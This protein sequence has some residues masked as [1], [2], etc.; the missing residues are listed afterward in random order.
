M[1]ARGINHRR[2]AVAVLGQALLTAARR[3]NQALDPCVCR[4]SWTSSDGGNCGS[5]QYGCPAQACDDDNDTWCLVANAPCATE[6]DD[7]WEWAYCTP[8]VNPTPSPTTASPSVDPTANP[9]ANPTATPT[10]FPTATPTANPTPNPTAYP[11]ANP[12]PTPTVNPTPN[13]TVN[14]TPNPTV[15][16]TPNPTANPTAN[17][18][19]NP[20]AFPPTPPPTSPPTPPPVQ[21][22]GHR[23]GTDWLDANSR[24]GPPCLS[25][26][27]CMVGENCFAGLLAG[28][29][30]TGFPTVFPTVFPSAFPS[31]N[32]PT[33]LPSV[34]YLA[35][36]TAPAIFPTFTTAA[37]IEPTVSPTF[38]PAVA[39]SV[40]AIFIRMH[41]DL[42]ALSALG[43]LA[44]ANAIV[45][46][47]QTTTGVTIDPAHVAV[48]LTP[49]ADAIMATVYC[50]HG[51]GISIKA[52]HAMATVAT[53]VPLVISN[54]LAFPIT[55][56]FAGHASYAPTTSDLTAAP[57]A[58]PIALVSSSDDSAGNNSSFG[59]SGDVI[60]GLVFAIIIVIGMAGV[61][62]MYTKK[63]K[64][65]R[66]S[67][68]VPVVRPLE[69]QVN[70]VD[71]DSPPHTPPLVSNPVWKGGDELRLNGPFDTEEAAPL[72]EWLGW[73]RN[74][75]TPNA[76]LLRSM[77]GVADRP[78]VSV[79]ADPDPYSQLAA[80]QT[81][82]PQTKLSTDPGCYSVLGPRQPETP[83]PT[84]KDI[85]VRRMTRVEENSYMELQRGRRST[86]SNAA[87]GDYAQLKSR[88]VGITSNDSYEA[89]SVMPA[90]S[91]TPGQQLVDINVVPGHGKPRRSSP[92]G[93]SDDGDSDDDA[94]QPVPRMPRVL[95]DGHECASVPKRMLEPDS[96]GLARLTP[97]YTH[98]PAYREKVTSDPEYAEVDAELGGS[99]ELGSSVF[100]APNAINTSA[101]LQQ[102]DSTDTISLCQYDNAD[103][104]AALQISEEQDDNPGDDD[105]DTISLCQY[106][107][108]DAIAALQIP[109]EQDNNADTISLRQYDNV[110]AIS[111]DLQDLPIAP[112]PGLRTP[113]L[114]PRTSS[115]S[116]L[117][118]MISADSPDLD[119]A[120]PQRK[121]A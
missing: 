73:S 97:V 52:S 109:K 116:K 84:G 96:R 117:Q 101:A 40:P 88:S 12:T 3:A 9:T 38:S 103:A 48:R 58:A 105:A 71:Q 61:A 36:T 5:T 49:D 17:P 59:I 27:D 62:K 90:R 4:D 87:D 121:V 111:E 70:T 1:A 43:Q 22:T 67:C 118:E 120:Q 66:D 6:V 55:E 99:D 112:L 60:A 46:M 64:R 35:P 33:T 56:C 74:I 11:T 45:A 32:I 24:C 94:G 50:S 13:P 82:Q 86:A 106:D 44:L 79:S 26:E 8:T 41:G 104:I 76:S 20:T 72:Y 93:F 31:G 110:D 91:V 100:A 19:P 75:S 77:D 15:N 51:S 102:Y 119:Y 28:P 54:G 29:C 23:C 39:G 25:P 2:L 37:M 7:E 30:E 113:A 16:P 95:Y 18:T 34:A 107:N 115:A 114:T 10:A 89:A 47:L 81:E 85:L 42:E 80:C 92:D 68:I 69:Q 14:P 53:A 98:V 21:S 78:S 108:A 83:Q 65:H 57:T 63:R